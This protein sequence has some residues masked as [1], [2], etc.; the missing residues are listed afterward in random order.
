MKAQRR[1]ELQTNSLAQFMDNLPAFLKL[2]G[3][4]ILLGI[5]FVALVIV[6]LRYRASSA[7]Q[8]A[9]A[10]TMSL[11][12]ARN[13]ISELKRF[14]PMMPPSQVASQ[15]RQLLSAAKDSVQTVL[16]ESEDPATKAQALLARGDLY[17]TVANLPPI[18]GAATQPSLQFAAGS[19]DFLKQAEDAY[20]QILKEYPDQKRAANTAQFGLAAVRENQERFD[21]ATKIYKTLIESSDTSAMFKDLATSRLALL[22]LAKTPVFVGSTQ[23]TTPTPFL[24]TKPTTNITS[25][26]S[27]Q[28][29]IK[30]APTSIPK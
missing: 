18:P 6:L 8:R 20:Q 16:D 4:K 11:G 9:E 30:T 3:N 14:D 5:I 26:P 12:N 22:E 24:T 15:R 23:P 17:W 1:H 21:D 25:M 7:E 29:A 10:V 28:A 13:G 19:E 27:S 2:H